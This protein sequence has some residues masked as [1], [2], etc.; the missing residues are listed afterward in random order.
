MKPIINIASHEHTKEVF[1]LKQTIE[2]YNKNVYSVFGKHP[3]YYI[4][5][6][7]IVFFVQLVILLLTGA[8]GNAAD[9]I[10]ISNSNTNINFANLYTHFITNPIY[11]IGVILLSFIE[12]PFIKSIQNGIERDEVS[13]GESP[14]IKG[15]G[16]YARESMFYVLATIV[17]AIITFLITLI[18][19]VGGRGVLGLIMNLFAFVVLLIIGLG[20][21]TLPYVFL[22]NKGLGFVNALK[23]SFSAG[24]GGIWELFKLYIKQ[25]LMIFL[26]IIILVF[27][28]F[29]A[30]PIPGV[31]IFLTTLLIMIGLFALQLLVK[32]LQIK[33]I[34]KVAKENSIF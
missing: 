10:N 15:L 11:L 34:S 26:G 1:F 12:I 4:G 32:L 30:I 6:F 17:Y 3:G 14:L 13:V 24:L 8:T 23:N 2:K 28:P 21:I 22:E 7:L 16:Y 33:V 20:Y 5:L 29:I 27:I 19:G 25:V 18:P 9:F 31:G